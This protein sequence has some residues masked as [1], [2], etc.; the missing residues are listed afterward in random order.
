LLSAGRIIKSYSCDLGFNSGHDKNKKGDG[1]TPEGMYRITKVMN[2]SKYY[3]AL[4]LNYPNQADREKFRMN[5]RAGLIA[6]NASIGGLIEI[7]G[8]GGTARDWTDGC[9]AISNGDMD[10]LIKKVGVGTPV[11]IV[12]R[13]ELGR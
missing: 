7:H 1:A 4:K 2:V 9:V 5:K 13:S 3:K 10:D 11:T 8:S 6:A 12:G